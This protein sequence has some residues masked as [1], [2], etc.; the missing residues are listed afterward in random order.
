VCVFACVCVG[1][2]LFVLLYMSYNGVDIFELDANSNSIP[3]NHSGISET[4][5]QIQKTVPRDGM[6]V[7]TKKGVKV[8]YNVQRWIEQ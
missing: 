8:V 3:G 1:F 2:S 7:D 5:R 6:T 4:I